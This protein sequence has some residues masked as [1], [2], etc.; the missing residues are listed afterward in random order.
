ME[1][2]IEMYT[3]KRKKDSYLHWTI[4]GQKQTRP[5]ATPSWNNT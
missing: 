5:T 1:K 3:E 4:T 2:E